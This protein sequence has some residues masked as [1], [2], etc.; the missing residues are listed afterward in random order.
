MGS[1]RKPTAG[2]RPCRVRRPAPV[3][4]ATVDHM[5]N[6]M[7]T[8]G[9][10]QHEWQEHGT[11]SG[12]SAQDYF[13]KVEQAFRSVRVP[14]QYPKLEHEQRLQRAGIGEELLRTPTMLH[15]RCVSYFLSRRENW[16]V[17]KSA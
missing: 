3:A 4:T 5:L 1:G 10:I 14:E 9:L 16:S 6:F 8:R 11:C 15:C 12:L 17:S 13:A 7:P 2:R